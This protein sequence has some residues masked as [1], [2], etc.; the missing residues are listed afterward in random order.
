MN[1][2]TLRRTFIGMTSIFLLSVIWG[3]VPAIVIAGDSLEKGWSEPPRDAK[4]RAYWWWLNG[5]VTKQ[6]ITRDLEEMRAKGFGGALICDA[7][8]SAQD[9]NERAPHGPDFMSPAWRELYRHALQEADRLGLE[10]S[11]NI[12]SGW[13]L[14]GPMVTPDYAAKKLVWSEIEAIGPKKMS[15]KLPQPAVRDGYYRDAI[16]VA[17]PIETKPAKSHFSGQVTASSSQEGFPVTNLQDGDLDSFWVSGSKTPAGGPTRQQPVWLKVEF[18]KAVLINRISIRPRPEYGPR[19]CEL[20]VSEDGKEYRSVKTFQVDSRKETVLTLPATRGSQFQLLVYDAFDRGSPEAPRNVQIAEMSLAGP[21]GIWPDSSLAK[22]PIRNWRQK[23]GHESL[24]F[25]APDTSLLLEQEE[26]EPGEQDALSDQVVDLSERLDQEGTLHWNVPPGRWQVLRFGYTIGNRSYV[27][28]CSEGWDGLSLD[29]LNAAAF[30]RYWDAVVDPLISD[31]GPLA[32]TTLKYLHT[33]S[34][35]VE[36]LNWTPA[37]PA[38]FHKRCGYSLVP[39]M[40][41]LAGRIV[42]DREASNRFLN[43]FRKT[44]GDLAIDNHY[45]PFRERAH[46]H[47]LL[48][49]PESGGP[50]AVPIDAQRCLGF[51]DVPMSEFWAWSW[52]HRVGDDNRFFVKQPASAAHTYGHRFV[53]AE[54]FTTIGP[55]WQE[56]LWDNLKPSF[57]KACC[58]GLNRLVWHE[59]V[60]SPVEQGMPGIQY[61]AGTHLNPNVTWWAKSEAFFSYINRCQFMLQQGRFVADVCYYYGDH[62]PNFAQHKRTDPAHV[63]PGYDYDVITEEVLLTRAS[64]KDGRI[65]LPDGM[66]YRV[67]VL[68]DHD[69]ISLPVLRKVE[70]LVNE[71]ATVIGPRPERAMSLQHSDANVTKI[72]ARLWDQARVVSNRSA[73]ELLV[74][75]NVPPDFQVSSDDAELDIDYI[76]RRFAGTDIYFV[77]NRAKKAVDIACAFRVSGK[78]P[79]FWDPVSGRRTKAHT[80]REKARTTQLP[81]R[82]P[83]CGSLFVVFR[84]PSSQKPTADPSSTGNWKEL[85]QLDGPWQVT[86]DPEW[87]GPGTITFDRLIDWTSH[88]MDGVKF[89][90]GTAAYSQAFTVSGDEWE[91]IHDASVYIELGDVRELAEVFVNGKSCG[92]TWT[93]PFRVDVT[94]AI[95]RGTNQLN[96]EVVNFW[97]NRIIGDA[98]LPAEQRR[99]RT[100]IRKLT[101]DT[102]LMRSGLFGPVVLQIV[103]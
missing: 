75:R 43:D 50:H 46:Q 32:G 76:H 74:E 78:T 1:R 38:E 26:A 48:I 58:E 49:H 100:N 79:E 4:L 10:M 29:V 103:E 68:R 27:S 96:V 52:R 80:F 7:D 13:N 17:I 101:H 91:Q 30:G 2:H 86:F 5:C 51:N 15:Q 55:H 6:A 85:V 44:L 45:R 36:P 95:K 31:A 69:A 47:E 23:A 70:Q 66:S 33:D 25:S 61:F 41:V 102:K 11:L 62:V 92:V 34:W 72:A 22:R 53:A 82:L 99:T 54:G 67:L 90:S 59:F 28:T 12:Q 93:P 35:E 73:R 8:G 89:Y 84:Q 94:D 3:L 98:A 40:P 87:G 60:C 21:D 37:M 39:W 65:V 16:L 88:E 83:P 42:E 97:P 77:A 19:E 63:L 64:V 57:D 24:H 14:G 81:L 20:Q 56:T 71:G 9:G 18:E